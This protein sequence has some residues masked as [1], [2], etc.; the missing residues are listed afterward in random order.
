M[1]FRESLETLSLVAVVILALLGCRKA[2]PRPSRTSATGSASAAPSATSSPMPIA[3]SHPPDAPSNASGSEVIQKYM[4]DLIVL[5]DRVRAAAEE[6]ARG[7]GPTETVRIPSPAAGLAD[8]IDVLEVDVVQTPYLT[9]EARPLHGGR[10]VIVND[11][12]GS[13]ASATQGDDDTRLGATCPS[14]LTDDPDAVDLSIHRSKV[15]LEMAVRAPGV[16]TAEDQALLKER[17]DRARRFIGSHQPLYER[18]L[19]AT[20]EACPPGHGRRAPAPGPLQNLRGFEDVYVWCRKP[21][22]TGWSVWPR[23]YVQG[24]PPPEFPK[25]GA[26]TVIGGYHPSPELTVELERFPDGAHEVFAEWNRP[27][28]HAVQMRATFL[29]AR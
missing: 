18:H 6:A 29:P 22:E 4:S 13:S 24:T 15:W 20:F 28:G 23:I 12:Q 9:V 2:A 16:C 27:S 26:G 11:L 19:E 25:H 8:R 5:T 21:N 3:S 1:R 7:R 10:R 14:M 17:I